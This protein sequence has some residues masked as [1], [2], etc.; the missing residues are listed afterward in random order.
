MEGESQS[1]LHL[2]Q[3]V[4][5]IP[6]LAMRAFSRSFSVR[7]SFLLLV[8]M[9]SFESEKSVNYLRLLQASLV[10]FHRWTCPEIAWLGGACRLEWSEPRGAVAF[11]TAI[12]SLR[13]LSTLELSLT[14][15]LGIGEK[16]ECETNAS[17]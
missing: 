1:A 5:V 3:M 11:F 2:G 9:S 7:F 15:S 13:M 17:L 12:A 16:E 14:L 8:Q 6:T 10:P 4:H